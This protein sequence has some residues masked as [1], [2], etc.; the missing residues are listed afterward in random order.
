MENTNKLPDSTTEKPNNPYAFACINEDFIQEGLTLRD[1]FASNEDGKNLS[2]GLNLKQM[3]AI[4]GKEPPKD[5]MEYMKYFFELESKLQFMKA[6]A[7]LKQR[8]L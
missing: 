6:D 2:E 8:E 4:M 1:Y 3:K 7:M 5:D